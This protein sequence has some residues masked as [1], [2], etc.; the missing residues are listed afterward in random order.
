MRV[1]HAT[2]GRWRLGLVLALMTMGAWATLPLALK[3]ALIY[4]DPYTLTWFRFLTAALVMGVWVARRGRAPARTGGRGAGVWWLLLAAAAML[5]ANYVLYLLGLD[6]T[7]PAVAQV[8]I[9]LAP[10]LMALGGIWLFG[11]HFSGT[12]WAGFLTLL[13]GLAV[14]FHRQLRT[15][16]AGGDQFWHGALFIGG[17][18]MAW[19]AYALLQKQLLTDFSSDRI[20]LFIY[21][22]AAVTLLSASAPATLGAL[23]LTAWP[24]VGYCALNTLIAYGAFSEA[25][26]HWEASRV[27]AVLAVTPLGT[28]AFGR[29]MAAIYPDAVP[30]ERLDGLSLVGAGLVVAGSMATSLA[31]HR[32]R[33]R[34][35]TAT[36]DPVPNLEA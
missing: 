2:T 14:F 36:A 7:T 23:D 29:L 34:T 35:G 27:S 30:P 9:Q 18:A 17:A 11:E 10:V 24:I 33:V 16:A 13:A 12:Q 22:F 31:G 26:N 8:L 3:T 19:A 15:F 20:M 28:I 21:L 6:L 4:L 1:R 32:R 25:L 5:T